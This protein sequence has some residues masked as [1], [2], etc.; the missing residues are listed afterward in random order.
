MPRGIKIGEQKIEM[1]YRIEFIY[2]LP[3]N[4][5]TLDANLELKLD[6]EKNIIDYEVV[7]ATNY[8]LVKIQK[9][10]VHGRQFY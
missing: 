8:E 10:R 2:F 7:N 9:V 1:N 5:V 3:W 4:K 6:D